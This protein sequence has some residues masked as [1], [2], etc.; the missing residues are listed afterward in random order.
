VKG[1]EG[2]KGV[3]GVKGVRD[4]RDMRDMKDEKYLKTDIVK[5]VK[6]TIAKVLGKKFL[7]N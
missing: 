2:I 4:V 6:F 7:I 5:R 1:I 3:K